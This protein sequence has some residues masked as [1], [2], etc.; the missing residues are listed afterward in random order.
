MKSLLFILF[1]LLSYSSYADVF[2]VKIVEA[3][4]I[5]DKLKTI[6][7]SGAV[8]SNVVNT[9]IILYDR[10]RAVIFK[11]KT[12]SNGRIAISKINKGDYTMEIMFK[13]KK[14]NSKVTISNTNTPV[15]KPVLLDGKNCM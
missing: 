11:G 1:F 4:P 12:D 10:K 5:P 8:Y 7:K 9:I 3:A 14:C 2:Q 6:K 15:I 13:D